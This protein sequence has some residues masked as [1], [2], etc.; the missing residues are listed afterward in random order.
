MQQPTANVI[1]RTMIAKHI[2]CANRAIHRTASIIVAGV[3]ASANYAYNTGR[4]TA[5]GAAGAQQVGLD[6]NIVDIHKAV[7]KT[8]HV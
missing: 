2:P 8:L 4:V 3:A 5:Q 7:Q 1:A 6:N